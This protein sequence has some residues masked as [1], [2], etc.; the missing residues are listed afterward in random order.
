M[1]PSCEGRF[2]IF[3]LPNSVS[4]IAPLI[5][6]FCLARNVFDGVSITFFIVVFFVLS[7]VFRFTILAEKDINFFEPPRIFNSFVFLLPSFTILV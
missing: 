2:V 3:A 6:M 1:F 5:N 7:F 4:I